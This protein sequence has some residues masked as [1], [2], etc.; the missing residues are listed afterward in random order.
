MNFVKVIDPE[1][2]TSF[3]IEN[4]APFTQASFYGGWHEQNGSVIHRF[5]VEEES[6]ILA[7]IQLI[8]LKTSLKQKFLYAPYGPILSGEKT[9][10]VLSLLKKELKKIT[11]QTGAIFLRLDFQ[12]KF[13]EDV[14]KVLK[15]APK[16]SNKGSVFQPRS[17]WALGLDKTIDEISKDF[18]QKNSLQYS[19]CRKERSKSRVYF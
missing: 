19:T 15:K 16:F 13:S 9:E 14:G 4:N 18:H 10:E 8:E 5:A 12:K 17:E 3:L 7:Y 1:K 11:K 2:Y 6:E